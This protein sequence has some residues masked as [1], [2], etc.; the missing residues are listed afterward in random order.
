MNFSG[1]VQPLFVAGRDGSDVEGQVPRLR[2]GRQ[3]AA[4]GKQERPG[5]VAQ[6]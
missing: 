4:D 5:I 6:R 3:L 2:G 1:S